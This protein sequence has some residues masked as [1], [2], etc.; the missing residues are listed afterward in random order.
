MGTALMFMLGMDSYCDVLL[1][2]SKTSTSGTDHKG[3]H[4]VPH[5]PFDQQNDTIKEYI[6]S[7]KFQM[8]QHEDKV[9][10]EEANRRLDRQIEF[11]GKE[12]FAKRRQECQKWKE[13]AQSF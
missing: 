2:D 9:L 13:Q 1:T 8:A 3:H 12:R 11:I 6:M 4:W 10:Y 5:V 7:E